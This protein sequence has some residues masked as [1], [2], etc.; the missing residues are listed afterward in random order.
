MSSRSKADSRDRGVGHPPRRPARGVGDHAAAANQAN[1]PDNRTPAF[2]APRRRETV[3]VFIEGATLSN[4]AVA[5]LVA[6]LHGAGHFYVARRVGMA[7]D[8]DAPMFRLWPGDRE[9]L[10]ETSGDWSHELR[11]LKDALTRLPDE[12]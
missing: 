2:V 12:L 1:P 10:L 9:L 6:R 5:E 4:A 11:P 7:L 8:V 3:A